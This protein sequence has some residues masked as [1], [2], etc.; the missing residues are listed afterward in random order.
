MTIKRKELINHLNKLLKIWDYQDYGPN[1]LQVQGTEEIENVAFAVSATRE[2]IEKAVQIGADALIVHHGL[3]W[4]FHSTKTLTNAFYHRVAPL[5]KNDINLMGY[6]LPLDGHIEFGNAASLAKKLHMT[7]LKPF[8]DYKG[9][10]TGVWGKINKSKPNDFK[11]KLELALNHSVMHSQPN[12]DDIESVG[13]I[14]GGANSQWVDCLK[15]NIQAYIT[16]E[17]SEHDWHEAK[18]S[19][20]HMFAG[21]HNATE[22]FGIQAIKEQLEKKYSDKNL[23]FTFISS[24]NPA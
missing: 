22:Q 7:D 13:I 2:S 12:Q 10:P 24:S 19:G 17:M 5:I 23:K 6:H 1:G 9:M 11:N 20:V 16:G 18:E 14:T 21:G 8:G 3:F 15:F 4:K